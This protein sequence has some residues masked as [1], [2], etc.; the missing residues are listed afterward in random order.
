MLI[1]GFNSWLEVKIS[2][3]GDA[4]ACAWYTYHS[5]KFI[6]LIFKG[7]W[8]CHVPYEDLVCLDK[9]V[10]FLSF[11]N[12]SLG[13]KVTLQSSVLKTKLNKMKL[14]PD[15]PQVQTYPVK[16]CRWS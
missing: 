15:K 13:L 9:E 7:E 16:V 5:M 1:F 3:K 8:V 11:T 4:Y 2:N 12:V 6:T 14:R 10:P